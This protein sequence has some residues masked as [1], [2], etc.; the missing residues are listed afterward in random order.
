MKFIVSSDLHLDGAKVPLC[1]T[2]RD[3]FE[4]QLNKVQFI[5]EMCKK[6]NAT[7]L[8]AGDVVDRA[9]GN[10]VSDAVHTLGLISHLKGM[11][12]ITGNHDQKNRSVKFIEDSLIYHMFEIG[13][14]KW[15]SDMITIDNTIL[16]GYDYGKDIEHVQRVDGKM[17][18][19]IYHGFVDTK[20]NKLIGGLVAKDILKEFYKDY[21]FIITGDHHKTF[22][23]EYG[24]CVLINPGSLLRTTTTQIDHKPCVWLVDTDNGSYEPIYIPIEDS[25]KV[26]ST[27]HI[28]ERKARNERIDTFITYLESDMEALKS[29]D[30]NIDSYIIE[31][32][33]SKAVKVF[34]TSCME[35]GYVY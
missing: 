14:F 20:E 34:I 35:D 25:S 30:K 16:Y 31:N 17:N 1:R 33:I 19:A 24:G 11:I 2:D 13:H 21:D 10:S 7:H 12:T 29:F 26:I 6:H 9:V 3:Y 22:T 8:C 23:E 15:L 27:D 4:T 28:E 18:I 5:N 32:K